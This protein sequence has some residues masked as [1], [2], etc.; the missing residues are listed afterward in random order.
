[1]FCFHAIQ[2]LGIQDKKKTN[3]P[4]ASLSHGLIVECAEETLISLS[5]LSAQLYRHGLRQK[6]KKKRNLQGQLMSF[7]KPETL[8]ECSLFAAGACFNLLQSWARVPVRQVLLLGSRSHFT[9]VRRI[10]CWHASF[11]PLSFSLCA[12]L[13]AFSLGRLTF[14]WNSAEGG[15]ASSNES[16][17]TV[18]WVIEKGHS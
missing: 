6:K 11:F 15:G 4:G 18:G 8:V 5:F 10:H 12:H 14:C 7:N 1:M 17:M 16:D 2:P 9:L 13:S 3:P